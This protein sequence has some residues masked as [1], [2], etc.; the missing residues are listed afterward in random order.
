MGREGTTPGLGRRDLLLGWGRISAP[1]VGEEES[2]HGVGKG[3]LL[4]APG[5]VREGSVFRVYGESVQASLL[6]SLV[7]WWASDFHGISPQCQTSL[8]L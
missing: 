5:L 6:S 4:L 1:G 8:R 3:N 7:C 2:T